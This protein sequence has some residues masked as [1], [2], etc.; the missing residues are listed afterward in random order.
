ML[1]SSLSSRW[2]LALALG[3]C[4]FGC[5]PK[6]VDDD[7]TPA[8]ARP[9]PADLAI[10]D[11]IDAKV[12]DKL[13]WKSVVPMADGTAKLVVRVGDAFK[14]KHDVKGELAVFTLD[15]H[16]LAQTPIQ[17][18][19][20]K[21][22]LEWPAKADTTYLVKVAATEGKAPYI[23]EFSLTPADPCAA[24]RCGAGTECKAGVCVAIEMPE[25]DCIPE[26][27]SG[28]FCVDGKCE[29]ACADGCPRGH[30]CDTDLNECVADACAGKKCGRGE[31]CSRGRCY[32]RAKKGCDPACGA[33]QTC[34]GTRCVSTK[35]EPEP[36]PSDD[37]P[38]SASIIQATPMG[39]KTSIILNKGSKHGVKVGQ[40]GSVKGVG[41]FRVIQVFATRCKAIVDKPSTALAGAKSATISR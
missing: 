30:V 36:E 12:G 28:K 11:T 3:L 23:T 40:S 24:M 33:G 20:M 6:Y 22:E 32:A 17:P 29:K 15:A 5:G 26:C 31:Y 41:S 7:H 39:A 19:V 38:I 16:Q 10:D 1:S 27:G 25:I 13:D 21:Y 9:A 2:S 18:N 4:A 34:K 8:T 37:G 35:T 14:G